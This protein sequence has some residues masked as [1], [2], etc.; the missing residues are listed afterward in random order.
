MPAVPPL[1]PMVIV[2]TLSLTL[3]VLSSKREANGYVRVG[4]NWRSGKYDG[5]VMRL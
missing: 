1:L 5:A 4:P 3:A 2:S